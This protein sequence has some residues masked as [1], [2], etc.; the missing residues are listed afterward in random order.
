[1]TILTKKIDGQGKIG[2]GK[3]P[4]EMRDI[5]K[6]IYNK[7][8]KMTKND[9]FNKATKHI[10]TQNLSKSIISDIN[11]IRNNKFLLNLCDKK[12]SCYVENI[13]EMDEIYYSNPKKGVDKNLYG[14][15]VNFDIHRDKIIPPFEGVSVYRVLIG[16]TDN[17]NIETKFIKFNK[18][19][20]LSNGDYMIFDFD[21]TEHKVINHGES[22]N[23]RVILKLH[24]LVCENCEKS[25]LY[26]NFVRKFYTY[27]LYITRYLNDEGVSPETYIQFLYGLSWQFGND[28][29]TK[30]IILL[31]MSVI[32]FVLNKIYK[33]KFKHKNIWK[34][35]KYTLYY[36]III[37]LS[38]VFFYWMR[39]KLFNIR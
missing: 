33:I 36:L 19:H 14:A 15:S 18:G 29:K 2:V 10:Y 23:K 16:L 34:L 35:T 30:Y 28:G 17:D 26:I 38:I 13:T 8:E 1:M 9:K 31:L 37:Y 25:K 4:I 5:L 3:L 12:N 24:Y 32:I 6:T 22:K 21:K 7:Y 39:F 27:Y 20:K 11:K